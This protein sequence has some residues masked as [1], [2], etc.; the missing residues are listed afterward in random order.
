M[1]RYEREAVEAEKRAKRVKR[2]YAKACVAV[3]E[4]HPEL[5]KELDDVINTMLEKLDK[6]AEKRRETRARNAAHDKVLKNPDGKVDVQK[7]K[8]IQNLLDTN[9]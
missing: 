6:Q 7:S 2:V 4:N 9:H 1:N 3:V 5:D 8:H